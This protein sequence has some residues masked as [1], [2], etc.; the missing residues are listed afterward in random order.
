M[1][2][3]KQ[4]RQSA[5]NSVRDFNKLVC[6]RDHLRELT[7]LLREVLVDLAHCVVNCEDNLNETLNERVQYA[8]DCHHTCTSIQIHDNDTDRDE[9]ND[10]N[11][12]I[13][14]T[15]SANSL[16]SAKNDNNLIHVTAIGD[17]KHCILPD[18]HQLLDVVDDSDLLKF[19]MNPKNGK[20][21][22][23]ID[24]EDE[25]DDA[26]IDTEDIHSN[27]KAD[28]SYAHSTFNLND[29]LQKLRNEA[30]YLLKLSHQLSLRKTE[31]KHPEN[32]ISVQ[33]LS[34]IHI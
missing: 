26:K 9:S 11:N 21:G 13:S 22:N 27:G 2:H 33:Q 12:S 30:D 28:P 6:E 23:Y 1:H 19:I 14:S 25:N 16:E 18:V 20:N 5:F 34:L 7:K 15:T 8:L 24:D 29:C 10:A 31:P 4:Q 32:F 3:R 17:M